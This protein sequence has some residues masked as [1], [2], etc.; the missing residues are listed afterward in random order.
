M[1][2]GMAV[3][4]QSNEES[5][6]TVWGEGLWHQCVYVGL[7]G[8]KHP[9][10]VWER[11]RG[12]LQRQL[13][14]RM[15]M[16]VFFLCWVVRIEAGESVLHPA[17]LWLSKAVSTFSLLLI[18]F[19]SVH[20]LQCELHT[21]RESIHSVLPSLQGSM[22]LWWNELY[23]LHK[24]QLIMTNTNHLYCCVMCCKLSTSKK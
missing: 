7:W 9:W 4:D 24:I 19:Q 3:I 11:E 23:H 10:C 6:V 22:K 14:V 18:H 13:S 5:K 8:C 2:Q 15:W 20:T 12:R 21:F 16:I 1:L 17:E